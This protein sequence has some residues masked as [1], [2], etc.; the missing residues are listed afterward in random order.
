MTTDGC[1]NHSCARRL[2]TWR[3]IVSATAAGSSCS[4]NLS[5]SQ[6][7][8]VSSRSWRRSR[9]KFDRSFSTHHCRLAC[10][11]VPCCGQECQKHPSRNTAILSF[12]KTKSGRDRVTPEIFRSTRKRRPRRCNRVRTCISRG[13]SRRGVL[14]IR[15]ETDAELGRGGRLTGIAASAPPGFTGETATRRRR[16]PR[17][18]RRIPTASAQLRQSTWRVWLATAGA[19]DR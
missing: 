8:A 4:Q 14:C 11:V 7:A 10:G 3:S 2:R 15:R 18:P 19:V 17:A 5:A 13:V 9:S 6:P 1:T 12:G 16:W